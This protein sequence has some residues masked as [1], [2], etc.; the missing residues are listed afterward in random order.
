MAW[1][2]NQHPPIPDN[3]Q[4]HDI[5]CVVAIYV[6]VNERDYETAYWNVKK[7]HFVLLRAR[8]DVGEILELNQVEGYQRLTPLKFAR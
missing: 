7:S 8:K 5:L 4:P 3:L 1:I 6:G 2:S